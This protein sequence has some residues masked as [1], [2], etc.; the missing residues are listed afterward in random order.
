MDKE[1]ILQAKIKAVEEEIRKTPYDK[2]TEHHHGVLKAKLARLRDE[3]D[4]VDQRKSSKGIGYALKQS[5]DA[6]VALLG[7]PS[8]GKSTLLNYLTKAE[9]L[10]GSY[11]FTTLTVIP[12]MLEY[13][14][15]KIQLLD[16]PGIDSKKT[17][18]KGLK[19]KVLS[20]VRAADLVILMTDYQ[21]LSWLSEMEEELYR[22]GFRLNLM[23]PKIK[24]HRTGK[25][26]IQIIDPYRNFD[27]AIIKSI[28]AELGFDNVIIQI[29]EKLTD[30]DELVDGLAGSR[31]YMPSI[32]LV[33]KLDAIKNYELRITNGT[34]GISAKEG[35]GIEELKE[36]IW[37]KLGLIRVYLRKERFGKADS[38]EPLIIK[39]DKT[40]AGVCRRVA[41]Q[42]GQN[43][44]RAWVWGQKVKF[45]GQE[46]SFSSPVFDEMEIYFGQ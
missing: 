44:K 33:N 25:G 37:K 4:K 19:K 39:N 17:V 9:S 13:K 34:I 42:T 12:G 23:P 26:G 28:T 15:V 7:P 2:S 46:M 21:R 32:K 24:V 1:E 29:E 14:G 18:N 5:G 27:E 35:T 20:V 22:N 10:V 8:S 40:I 31:Q 16:L 36:E 41:G 3:V 30:V 38:K 11:D 6:T 45:P 43:F